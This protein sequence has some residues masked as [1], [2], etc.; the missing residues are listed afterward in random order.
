MHFSINFSVVSYNQ[1][2]SATTKDHMCV[3]ITK[4][5]EAGEYK[6]KKEDIITTY[7]YTMCI[8]IQDS[9]FK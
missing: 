6:E 8:F 1:K 3:T 4:Q 2:K 9:N 7:Y 5:K